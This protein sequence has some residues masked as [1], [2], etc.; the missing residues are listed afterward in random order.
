MGDQLKSPYLKRDKDLN[1]LVRLN[2]TLEVW[3]NNDLFISAAPNVVQELQ[4]VYQYSVVAL[5]IPA[6]LSKWHLI[7]ASSNQFRTSGA[8]DFLQGMTPRRG[9]ETNDLL[10][11]AK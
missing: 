7:T 4:L 11:I 3:G 6:Q 10:V 5:L 8:W 2:E 9:S 1:W